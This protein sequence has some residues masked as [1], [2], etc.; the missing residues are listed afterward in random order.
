VW[1]S[2]E[3]APGLDVQAPVD[4]LQSNDATLPP[5]LVLG[6]SGMDANVVLLASLVEATN[7]AIRIP[8]G[9]WLWIRHLYML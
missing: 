4:Q 8:C 5:Y 7:S 9:L 1:S 3:Q 2:L 6:S